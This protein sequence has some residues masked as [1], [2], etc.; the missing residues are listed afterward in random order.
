MNNNNNQIFNAEKVL[1][2][3]K[4]LKEHPERNR[5]KIDTMAEV[6]MQRAYARL[7][8]TRTGFLTFMYAS[9][10]LQTDWHTSLTAVSRPSMTLKAAFWR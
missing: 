6:M 10:Y 2:K 3:E 4:E 9:N 8:Q 5:V 1:A 7:H